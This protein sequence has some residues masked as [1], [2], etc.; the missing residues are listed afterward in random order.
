MERIVSTPMTMPNS[1]QCSRAVGS[2]RLERV[3][4]AGVERVLVS[5]ELLDHASYLTAQVIGIV[6]EQL[7]PRPS[8]T[9]RSSPIPPSLRMW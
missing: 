4:S 9:M 3:G 5:I 6:A 7:G 1:P 8:A 2:Q